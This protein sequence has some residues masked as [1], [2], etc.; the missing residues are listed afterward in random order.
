MPVAVKHHWIDPYGKPDTFRVDGGTEF[1]G[2]FAE[3]AASKKINLIV[4]PPGHP[5]S[6]GLVERS[7]AELVKGIKGY[8][9]QEHMAKD[10]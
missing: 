5:Q 2:E 3:T 10:E 4:A 8:L 9:L 7:H 6:N 1:L